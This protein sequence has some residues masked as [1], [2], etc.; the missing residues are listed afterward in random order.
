[1]GQEA[2]QKSLLLR[3]QEDMRM[4]HVSQILADNVVDEGEMQAMF[5]QYDLDSSGKLDIDEL[6]DV[7]AALVLVCAEKHKNSTDDPERQQA[8]NK[9]VL[10]RQ[11]REFF[12]PR[13][14][15][16]H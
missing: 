3:Q 15:R 11:G 2:V 4:A 8:K 7:C 5:E 1:M 6:S 13:L 12:K 10:G 14:V 9:D 16:K